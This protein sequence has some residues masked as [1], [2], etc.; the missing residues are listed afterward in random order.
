MI[1]IDYTEIILLTI[2]FTVLAKFM[3]VFEENKVF[4]FLIT[5]L[6]ALILS[7]LFAKV[8]YYYTRKRY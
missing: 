2:F 3:N 1:K 7:L 6:I 8:I 5:H 4:N